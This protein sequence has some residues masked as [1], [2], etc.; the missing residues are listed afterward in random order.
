MFAKHRSLVGLDIGLGAV[1]AVELTDRGGSL[2]VTGFGQIECASDDPAVRAKAVA[3]L[4]REG[5]F[6]SKRVVT[7]LSGKQVIVRYLTLPKMA[8]DE[9]RNAA[10]FEAGKYVPFPLDECVMDVKP[11]EEGGDRAGEGNMTALFVAVRRQQVDEHLDLVERAGLVSEIVDV[12]AFALG[13]ALELGVGC[14][15]PEDAQKALALI[16]VGASKTCVNIVAGGVSMFTREIY[17]GGRDFTQAVARRLNLESR[18]AEDLKRAPEDEG[19]L[20]EAVLPLVDDLANE[21]QISFDYF[22][23]QFERRI[24]ELRL[25]GGGSRL[26]LL[27]EAFERVFERP[28][29]PF[30][31]F[32]GAAI[33]SAVDRDLLESNAGRLAVAAG[34]AARLKRS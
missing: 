4:F 11:V 18:Q 19:P 29:K 7:G 13:N 24:D 14:R 21:I 30:N 26:G 27:A 34:L 1:K 33:D 22:E 32:E 2:A 3:E 16:D 8:G 5:G 10:A 20:R 25:S 23:H 6:R 17:L 15:A 28:A 12:D 9:L 31:P